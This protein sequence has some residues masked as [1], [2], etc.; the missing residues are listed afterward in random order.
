MENI[1]RDERYMM[2][3]D[4]LDKSLTEESTDQP[5]AIFAL[6]MLALATAFCAASAGFIVWYRKDPIITLSQPY[7]LA[8]EFLAA[9]T[10]TMSGCLHASAKLWGT[11]DDPLLQATCRIVIICFPLCYNIVYMALFGKLWRI[12]K[13]TRLRRNQ[14]ITIRQTIWPLRLMLVINISILVAWML[15]DPPTYRRIE[16]DQGMVGTCDFMNHTFF[17]AIQILLGIAMALSFWMT[18]MTKDLPD[19]LND[20]GRI[21]SVFLGNAITTV[22]SGSLYWIGWSRL[23]PHLMNTGIWSAM[24]F[25]STTSIAP[26]AI[27]KMYHVWYRKKHGRLPEGVGSIGQGSVHV[28]NRG[29]NPNNSSG[30]S[31]PTISVAGRSSVENQQK[32]SA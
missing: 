13:V 3:E 7:F 8:V 32:M 31:S 2:E 4:G 30:V 9:G 11:D 25:T 19:D 17:W 6:V 10:I 18:W 23:N 14:T 1:P 26:I 24:F 28:S 20:G 12:K 21:F 15:V 22:F 5:L 27:P 16:T 29:S